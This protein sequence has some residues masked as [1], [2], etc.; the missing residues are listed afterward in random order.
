[1]VHYQ[2]KIEGI[3]SENVGRWTERISE[4]E[5][6]VIE[7]WLQDVMK[8]FDYELSMTSDK[9]SLFSEFYKWYNCRYFYRDSFNV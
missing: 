1:M 6:G 4:C 8:I 7:F 3:S 5:V 9:A 2:K